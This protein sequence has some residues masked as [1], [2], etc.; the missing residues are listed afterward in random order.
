MF[1]LFQTHIHG[2][3]IFLNLC[4]LS[5]SLLLIIQHQITGFDVFWMSHGSK[6]LLQ[7]LVE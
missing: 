7:S 5:S 2:L 3:F 4:Y 1:S 6:Q